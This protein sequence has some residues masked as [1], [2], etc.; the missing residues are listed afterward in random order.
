VARSVEVDLRE[1]PPEGLDPAEISLRWDRDALGDP[2]TGALAPA[3]VFEVGSL[4]YP[5]AIALATAGD[6]SFFDAQVRSG[7]IQVEGLLVAAGTAE[8]LK[9][10]VSR[11]RPTT[12]YPA[13]SRPDDPEYDIE[14]EH[15]FTSFPSG[16][17]TIAWVSATTGMTQLVLE[18]P[19][20]PFLAHFASGFAAGALGASVSV[21]RVE[22]E[23]HHPSDAL[24]GA[25]L[26]SAAGV[27]IPLLHDRGAD[28]PRGPAWKAALLGLAA[29][30]GA[31][32]LI[33]P[34]F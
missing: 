22:A 19:D 23:A 34:R 3:D 9:R 15:A 11:P 32:L 4:L 27:T 6:A 33:V 29:G 31:A 1:V 2:E 17:S 26:G 21:L 16:H 13:S 30:T 20:L 25:L 28:A 10:L 7:W 24:A 14:A 8:L 5:P 18:R 12:Y